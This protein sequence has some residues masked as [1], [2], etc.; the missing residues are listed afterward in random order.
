MD[1]PQNK[2]LLVEDSALIGQRIAELVGAVPTVQLVASVASEDE[3]VEVLD[4]ENVDA[5]ILDL[6]LRN[7]SGLGVLRR[8]ARM[9]RQPKPTVIVYTNYDLPEYRREAER[10]GASF[11]LDKARD[12]GRLVAI[13]G[14]LKPASA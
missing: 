11:F 5:V 2:V 3:A 10:L 6:H 14:G 8:L 4:R 7:G 1:V 13:L 12:Y 9:T